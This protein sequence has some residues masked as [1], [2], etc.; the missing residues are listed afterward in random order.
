MII[1]INGAFGAGKTTTAFE[2]NRKIENSYIYDPENVGYFIR[3]NSP[4]LF[5]RG[6]FQ[7]IPLWRETNYKLIK[8]IYDNYNGTIIIPMTI[9]NRDYFDEIISRLISDGVDLKHFILYANK[10]TIIKRLKKR[11]IPFIS[12]E[13]FA[14]DRIDRCIYAFDNFITETKIITDNMKVSEIVSEIADKSGVP[15]STPNE[16]KLKEKL[17][18]LIFLLKHIRM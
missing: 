15:L 14:F 16:S 3:K 17:D 1:W 8:L 13:S 11:S 6:D 10:N 7:D 9:V 5:S 4:E 2:L 12:D 18:K